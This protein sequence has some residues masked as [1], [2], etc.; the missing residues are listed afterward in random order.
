MRRAGR[1]VALLA[2]ACSGDAADLQARADVERLAKTEGAGYERALAA[3]AAHGRRAIP[4]V[5][6]ALH[7]APPLARL[8]LL[9]ALRRIGDPE[10]IPLLLHRA[11]HDED[12]RVRTDARVTLRQW[13]DG[14]DARA[15]DAARAALTRLPAER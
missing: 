13:A 15:A 12:E 8:N 10:A 1:C 6:T 14:A 9:A 3:V 4:P 11:A 5:E 2:L 7:D